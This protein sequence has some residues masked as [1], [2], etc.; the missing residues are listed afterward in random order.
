MGKRGPTD[1]DRQH[2]PAAEP[3][4]NYEVVNA[5][6][7]RKPAKLSQAIK[8]LKAGARDMVSMT[9]R[10]EGWQPGELADDD[11]RTLVTGNTAV[12]QPPQATL[13][14]FRKQ[15]EDNTARVAEQTG[16][17]TAQLVTM[18]QHARGRVYDI[19]RL[20]A[21]AALGNE[22]AAQLANDGWA[23]VNPQL[24]SEFEAEVD[25]WKA[26]RGIS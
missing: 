2:I 5:A 20:V 4:P 17:R 6:G 7:E 23:N 10:Q 15:H 3:A 22:A 11:D 19:G 25:G 13:V 18:D 16:R 8:G 9:D 26:D 21:L 14:A 12:Q 24:I 1:T